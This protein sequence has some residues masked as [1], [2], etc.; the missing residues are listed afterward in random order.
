[1]SGQATVTP[2]VSAASCLRQ[3]KESACACARR[4]FR[5]TVLIELVVG[6]VLS[7]VNHAG[8]IVDRSATLA[9]WLRVVAN[10]VV[11]F[12]VSSAGLVTATRRPDPEATL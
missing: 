6:T 1:M 3:E 7:L 2:L 9:A 8:L 5:R 11:P 10:Y 4:G 12:C